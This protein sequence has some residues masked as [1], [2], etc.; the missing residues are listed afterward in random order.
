MKEAML[1]EMNHTA[2]IKNS[3]PITI[4]FFKKEA[5]DNPTPMGYNCRFD[6]QVA[7]ANIGASMYNNIPMALFYVDKETGKSAMRPPF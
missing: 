2:G 1:Y 5:C 3:E 7:S 6:V 4:K